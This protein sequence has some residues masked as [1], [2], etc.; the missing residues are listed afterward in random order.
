M[1][2][3][4]ERWIQEVL[5]NLCFKMTPEERAE[6]ERGLRDHTARFDAWG[7]TRKAPKAREVSEPHQRL[8]RTGKK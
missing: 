3:M 2:G 4:M 1:E 7:T 8:R 5:N 6:F